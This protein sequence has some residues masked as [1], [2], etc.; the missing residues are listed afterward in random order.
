MA[1]FYIVLAVGVVVLNLPRFPAVM[2]SIFCGRL[3]RRLSPAVTV[4]SLFISMQKGVSGALLQRA[5]PWH[6]LHRPRLRRHEKAGQAGDVFGIFEVLL[7][8]SLSVPLQRWSSPMQRHT[9]S[10][11]HAWPPGRFDDLR[12]YFTTYRRLGIHSRLWRSCCVS[13][14]SSRLGPVR[15]RLLRFLCRSQQGRSSVLCGVLFRVILVHDGSGPDVEYSRYLQ[16]PDEY[17]EPGLRVAAAFRAQW[18]S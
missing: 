16:R 14:P 17:P 18:R 15:P 9:V 13:P 5:G 11:C 6:R 4:G 10:F 8:Q 7:I 2:E 3:P 12:L 1:L